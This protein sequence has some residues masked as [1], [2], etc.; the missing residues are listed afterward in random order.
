MLPQ[1][2]LTK[3]R[4]QDADFWQSRVKILLMPDMDHLAS[5]LVVWI[6]FY[7]FLWRLHP[8]SPCQVKCLYH[9][10][11]SKTVKN[12]TSQTNVL[13]NLGLALWQHLTHVALLTQQM[14]VTDVRYQEVLARLRLG[15]CNLDDYVLL[16]TRILNNN[17][18]DTITN[19]TP[20]IVLGNKL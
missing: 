14:L 13:C 5:Q 8:I 2:S 6:C 16:S 15:R 12:S 10:F 7:V 20:V 4:W 17:I 9:R 19:G 11:G 1:Q 3:Y 18:N